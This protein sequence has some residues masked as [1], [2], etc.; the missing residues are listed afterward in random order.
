MAVMHVSVYKS[1]LH[2][3]CRA[4]I[5]STDNSTVFQKLLSSAADHQKGQKRS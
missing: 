5:A 3:S 1:S 2:C 4:N